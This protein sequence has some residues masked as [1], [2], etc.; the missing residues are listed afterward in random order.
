MIAKLTGTLDSVG[1]DWAMVDV[2]GVGYRLA[3]SARTL[4]NLAAVGEPVSFVVETR[5][6]DDRFVLYG[7]SEAAES[8]WFGQLQSVQGVG[9]KVALA[10]LSAFSVDDMRNAIAAQDM[11]LMTR[12]EGVGRKLAQRIVAELKDKVGEM[13]AARAA[14]VAELGAAAA[15]GPAADAVSALVNLGYRRA[16]AFG[17]IAAA[18]QSMGGEA[19][20]DALIRGGL[21]ELSR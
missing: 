13:P 10:L 6:R 8:E 15:A 7:F 9:A 4:R 20:L 11:T 14:T 5:F 21:R 17:A 1:A 19:G 18:A 3:C 12:A 2:G 16:E